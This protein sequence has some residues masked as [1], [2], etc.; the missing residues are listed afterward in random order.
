VLIQHKV[1]A[2]TYAPHR[3]DA[4]VDPRR[5]TTAVRVV[6]VLVLNQHKVCAAGAFAKA[7]VAS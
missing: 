6:G 4:R 5:A 2:R 7:S 1:T 3:R